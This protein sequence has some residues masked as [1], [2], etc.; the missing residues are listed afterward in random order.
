MSDVYKILTIRLLQLLDGTMVETKVC[1]VRGPRPDQSLLKFVVF[2]FGL[3][4]FAPV[5]IFLAMVTYCT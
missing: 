1:R 4:F 3:K 5:F 2:F